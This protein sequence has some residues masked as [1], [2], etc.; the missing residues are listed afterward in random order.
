MN[1]KAIGWIQNHPTDIRTP[2]LVAGD[3]ALVDNN[4]AQNTAEEILRTV[5]K[6]NP[7][8]PEV[9]TSLA[10]LLQMTENTEESAKIYEQILI[11]QPD[12]V[13]AINN[14]AWIRCEEQGKYQQA[15][16]LAQQ[17]LEKAPDYIDLI[18]TRGVAYYRTGEFNKAVLDL[19]YCTKL[20]PARTPSAVASYFHLARALAGLG[21]KDD[22]LENLKKA[23][24][25]DAEIG[26]LSKT[27]SAEAQYLLEELLRGV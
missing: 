1:Q 27:D 9:M 17:G 26:G 18:N 20:Y 13:I 22:A 7:D 24:E 23:L 2:I 11:L 10:M 5:L 3:L 16:E 14:L 4:H 6:N 12:N 8:A 19:T 25:L 15:V 21:Q